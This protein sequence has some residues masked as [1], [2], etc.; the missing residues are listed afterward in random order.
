MHAKLK[1]EKKLEKKKQTKSR[2]AAEKRALELGE[3]FPTRLKTHGTLLRL[4]GGMMMKNCLQRMLVMNL[5]HIS[6]VFKHQKF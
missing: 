1:Q 5:V 3:E 6:A 2:D 4:F